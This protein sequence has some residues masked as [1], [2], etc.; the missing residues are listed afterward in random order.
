LQRGAIIFGNCPTKR[1][2]LGDQLQRRSIATGCR[3]QVGR[4]AGMLKPGQ[5]PA[6]EVAEPSRAIGTVLWGEVER[7]PGAFDLFVKVGR[8]AVALK[9]APQPDAEVLE[10]PRALGAVL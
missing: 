2:M 3:I 9:A 4:I 5:Q 7:L 10:P 8:I 6:A 1:V